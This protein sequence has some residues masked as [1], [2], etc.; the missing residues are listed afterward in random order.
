MISGFGDSET[1]ATRR[2]AAGWRFTRAGALALPEIPVRLSSLASSDLDTGQSVDCLKFILN[3]RILFLPATTSTAATVLILKRIILFSKPTSP[4]T[5]SMTARAL[6]LD[7]RILILRC[8]IRWQLD[9]F[10]D[11]TP[12]LPSQAHSPTSRAAAE[13]IEPKT[14]N[15]LP[16]RPQLHPALL[17]AGP[18]RA[19]RSRWRRLRRRQ[20]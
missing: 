4:A 1:L 12:E 9:R 13:E 10:D 11:Y 17:P 18:R 6:I 15:L 20:F 8:K 19:W 7:D 16:R 2:G 3:F 5:T 14:E